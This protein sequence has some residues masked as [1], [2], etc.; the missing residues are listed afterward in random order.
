M[1]DDVPPRRLRRIDELGEIDD[2]QPRDL[3]LACAMASWQS[4]TLL[5][6]TCRAGL[7]D[8]CQRKTMRGKIIN[9]RR[10]QRAVIANSFAPNYGVAT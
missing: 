6:H 8:R 1:Q 10:Y 7:R 2:A 9:R 3:R 4:R 5:A